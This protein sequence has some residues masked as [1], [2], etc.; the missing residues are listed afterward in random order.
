MDRDGT[1][2]EEVGYL[3]RLEELKLFPE[4]YEAVRLINECG[5]KTIVITNQ[6]GVAR[7]FFGEEFI[8]TVHNR[9]NEMLKE[10]HAFID[11]F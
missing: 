6:S 7:G 10:G 5:M 9:I 8:H 4:T 2:N 11:H 1:I 3:S